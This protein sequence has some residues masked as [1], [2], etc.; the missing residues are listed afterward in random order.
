MALFFYF[1]QLC[2]QTAPHLKNGL[3][4]CVWPSCMV[5]NSHQSGVLFHAPT[6]T[7]TTV[8]FSE[9]VLVKQLRQWGQSRQWRVCRRVAKHR[10]KNT[11]EDLT[12]LAVVGNGLIN[13]LSPRDNRYIPPCLL[14][15]LL[16]VWQAVVLPQLAG[17]GRGANSGDKK[18]LV[19]LTY[20][21]FM[22]A[23]ITRPPPAALKETV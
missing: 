9:N 20:S 17:G 7:Q 19:F 15:S 14:V 1:L 8:Q 12:C 4:E 22:I 10:K 3:C 5:Y 16:S 18:S 2:L 6:P 21:C 13:P 23:R 11:R